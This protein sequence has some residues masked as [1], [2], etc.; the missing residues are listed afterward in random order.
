MGDF[1]Q[2]DQAMTFRDKSADT[3]LDGA[4]M[5]EDFK[6]WWLSSKYMQVVYSGPN[7]RQIA[8]DGWEARQPEIDALKG[9]LDLAINDA[10]NFCKIGLNNWSEIQRLKAENDR[11]REC[12][13]RVCKAAE[14]FQN[15]FNVLWKA[16]NPDETTGPIMD[17]EDA[18]HL[19]AGA[20]IELNS[21]IHYMRKNAAMKDF[22]TT[23]KEEECDS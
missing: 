14:G 2:A 12:A 17:L 15:A 22:S 18:V 16:E 1:I 4:N 23:Q 7:S 3:T 20:W 5:T 11:L 6:K 8:C 19:H 21:A 10:R 9:K 13:E